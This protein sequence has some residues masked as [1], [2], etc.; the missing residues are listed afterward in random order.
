MKCSVRS[1]KIIEQVEEFVGNH[2]WLLLIMSYLL[3]AICLSSQLDNVFYKIWG[4]ELFYNEM[5][6]SIVE[7]GSF[8]FAHI[9]IRAGAYLYPTILAIILRFF[10]ILT[11]LHI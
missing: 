10:I 3:I 9:D 6:R 2:M 11:Q 8:K 1:K 4:D 5:A 7:S